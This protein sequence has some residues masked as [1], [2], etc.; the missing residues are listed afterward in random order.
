[1]RISA[2]TDVG[3]IA[4][5]TRLKQGIRLSVL[6]QIPDGMSPELGFDALELKVL[7]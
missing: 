2:D 7:P 4:D 3:G 5:R 1:L 6:Y